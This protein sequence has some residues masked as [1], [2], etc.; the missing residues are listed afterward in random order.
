VKSVRV[1]LAAGILLAGSVLV[2]AFN[3]NAEQRIV[4]DGT[5]QAKTVA[6]D[7]NIIGTGAAETLNIELGVNVSFTAGDGDRVN[8]PY[9]LEHYEITSL[10]NHIWFSDSN[11]QTVVTLSVTG[12]STVSFPDGSTATLEMVFSHGAPPHVYLGGVVVGPTPLDQDLVEL[13]N[14]P[15]TASITSPS[16]NSTY[17]TGQSISFSGTGTDP[18]D[19]TLPSSAFVWVSSRDGQINS[20]SKSFDTNTLSA[21]IHEITLTVINSNETV[22]TAMIIITIIDDVKIS[23]QTLIDISGIDFIQDANYSIFIDGQTFR[24]RAAGIY[25]IAGVANGLASEIISNSDLTATNR[26][27]VIKVEG[28]VG[29]FTDIIV[30]EHI[31]ETVADISPPSTIDAAQRTINISGNVVGCASYFL[32][33]SGGANAG[34]A[35]TVVGPTCGPHQLAAHLSRSYKEEVGETAILHMWST[36]IIIPAEENQGKAEIIFTAEL[37]NTLINDIVVKEQTV[38]DVNKISA[39]YGATYSIRIGYETYSFKAT[40]SNIKNI[41]RGLAKD[42]NSGQLMASASEGIITIEGSGYEFASEN[43]II[44]ITLDALTDLPRPNIITPLNNSSYTYGEIV[45]FKGAGN[46]LHGN[47]LPALAFN[48]RSDRDGLIETG[49][50]EFSTD[51]L[52]V[53]DHTIILTAADSDGKTG[54]VTVNLTVVPPDNFINFLGMKFIYIPHGAFMMGSPCGALG[55]GRGETQHK[56]THTQG[57]YMQTTQVTQEQWEAVTGDN[58]SYFSNCGDDCPVESI[59]WHDAQ[60]FISA[61]NDLEDTDRYALPTEAQWEYAARAGSTTAFA[62]GEITETGLGYDPVL[63]SMGWYSYNSNRSTQPVAQKDPNAWG[64]YDMHG[65]V[66]EWVADWYGTYPSSAVTDPTGPS[67]GTYRV[68]RGGSWN[69]SASL[70]RSSSR[71]RHRPDSQFS[72][73]GFRLVLLPNH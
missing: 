46:D 66:S 21:G 32:N 58:P 3:A 36:L 41:A 5:G 12:N 28:V 64:L 51:F 11:T 72:S 39:I 65:N 57:Y 42:I 59:S 40:D 63:D 15:P 56:V 31:S 48:W 25:D 45:T 27:G 1:I 24:F 6:R 10:G 19:G 49:N 69:G 14:Q 53:G 9:D 37:K 61:L 68:L 2:Y 4:L 50:K 67:S 26:A 33:F 55:R 20:G 60:D 38:I 70:C 29:T 18:E 62:N 7:A 17:T 47:S 34:T 35:T 13:T 16:N 71:R 44:N 8:L 30:S 73:L 52:S 22:N 54:K 43:G 23:E